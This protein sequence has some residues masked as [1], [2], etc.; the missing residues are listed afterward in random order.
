M[1]DLVNVAA[2]WVLP[3]FLVGLP[4]YGYLRGVDVYGE[5]VD[6]AQE[7]FWTAIKTIPFMVAILTAMAIFRSSGALTTLLNLASPVAQ[8]LHL[9]SE[10][11]PLVILRPLSGSA[12]FAYTAD[13]MRSFGPDSLLGRLGSAIQ[14]STDTTF[15]VLTV[16]FGSVGIKDARYAPV[17]GIMGDVGGFVA[18]CLLTTLLFSS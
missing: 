9:P 15:F 4:L 16:Y 10:I 8:L 17:V 18:A 11:L 12:S 14:G 6:G 3:V 5:F 2:R 1:G 7:G 13:L